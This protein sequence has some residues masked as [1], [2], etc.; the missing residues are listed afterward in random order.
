MSKEK[1]RE[2]VVD[3]LFMA[4]GLEL[5]LQ[6]IR[7]TQSGIIRQIS[8]I[9]SKYRQ[10]KNGVEYPELQALPKLQIL[11]E[12]KNPNF[13]EPKLESYLRYTD[14]YDDYIKRYEIREK[15]KTIWGVNLIT[16]LFVFYVLCNIIFQKN[17]SFDNLVLF[18]IFTFI[19]YF[20]TTI[21][22]IETMKRKEYNEHC[23][24]R[25]NDALKKYREDL[26]RYEEN[27][28]Y[29]KERVEKQNTQNEKENTR[30][31][32]EYVQDKKFYELLVK[33]EKRLEKE[34]NKVETALN[35]L[36]NSERIIPLPY[37]NREMVC[38]LYEFMSTSGD[39]FDIKFALERADIS[40]I[41]RSFAQVIQNQEK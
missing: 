38:Y 33:D 35:T 37:R 23:R 19:V 21:I 3:Y 14:K 25:Y 17:F 6:E 30:L 13:L 2:E 1:T 39:D 7:E 16:C 10:S 36:Y 12:Y 32:A 27:L 26:K 18:F 34:L 22:R 41:K 40:E 15:V 31:E 28:K 9:L 24:E 20:V 5:L 8:T 11:P 29:E 4:R